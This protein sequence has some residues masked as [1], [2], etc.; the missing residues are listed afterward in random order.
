MRALDYTAWNGGGGEGLKS[1]NLQEGGAAEREATKPKQASP[2]RGALGGNAPLA[3]CRPSSASGP[4][5][6][7]PRGSS[8]SLTGHRNGRPSE[9]PTRPLWGSCLSPPAGT[10]QAPK[11]IAAA[12][13]APTNAGRGTNLQ[14]LPVVEMFAS[15]LQLPRPPPPPV[16]QP[17]STTPPEMHRAPT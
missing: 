10:S 9:P 12:R 3:P 6:R 5:T 7:S 15:A 8:T 13:P 11:P 14:H 17:V 1:P 16:C 4:G 2:Q